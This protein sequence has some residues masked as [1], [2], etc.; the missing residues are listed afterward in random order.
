MPLGI[1][2]YRIPE[3]ILVEDLAEVEKSIEHLGE[4]RRIIKFTNAPN[5]LVTV[6]LYD[7]FAP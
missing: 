5:S 4:N 7:T 3:V 6:K 2:V 1:G